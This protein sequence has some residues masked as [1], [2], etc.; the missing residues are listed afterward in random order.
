MFNFLPLYHYEHPL[1][2]F[3]IRTHHEHQFL[4]SSYIKEVTQVASSVMK[5]ILFFLLCSGLTFAAN[6]TVCTSGFKLINNKCW[7]LFTDPGNHTIAERTCTSYGGTLFTAKNAIDNRAV[8]N[9]VSNAGIDH[10]WIGIFCVGNDKSQCYW[11]DQ[12]GTTVSYDNFAVGFPDAGTGRCVYYSIPG[13]PSGQ[14]LN[15]DCTRELAYVCELPPTQSDICDLNF[16][17]NCYFKFDALPFSAAQ[18]QCQQMCGNLVSIHSAEENRF[19]TSI[20]SHLSYDFIR[21]GG[22][23]TSSDF[24]VW[25]DGS[26]MDYTNLEKFSGSSC[27]WMSLTTSNDYSYGAWY[28]RDCDSPGHFLCKRPVGALNCRGTPSPP[29]PPPVPLPTPTCT[30]G[31]YM[32]PGNITSPNYPNYYDHG[33]QYTLTTFGS[34]R[35]RFTFRIFKFIPTIMSNCMMVIQQIL[36]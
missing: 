19:I 24:I 7:K 11:D 9:F 13:S 21:I 32:A 29:T 20:Y 28:T 4:V 27:L 5:T 2:E 17:N 12:K 23:A 8:G 35:I 10:L 30:T 33:C 36:H 16:N 25:T 14:W 22:V 18:E 34:N 15:G 3:V 1:P 6:D 26:T 31:V